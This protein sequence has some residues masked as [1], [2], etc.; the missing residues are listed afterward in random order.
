MK[1]RLGPMGKGI[2]WAT[3]QAQA[4]GLSHAELVKA[5]ETAAKQAILRGDKQVTA[6]DLT[7]ALGDRQAASSE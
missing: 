7:A 1:A 2:R 3:A 5:A 4:S 6:A